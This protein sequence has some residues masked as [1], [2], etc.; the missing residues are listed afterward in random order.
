MVIISILVIVFFV[1]TVGCLATYL[2]LKHEYPG[3]FHMLLWAD[4]KGT[5]LNIFVWPKFW[6]Q[7]LK[8][9]EE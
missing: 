9:G 7:V 8:Q 3:D 4:P 2:F 5:V 1:W 6:I